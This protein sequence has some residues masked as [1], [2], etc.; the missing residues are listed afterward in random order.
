[1]TLSEAEARAHHRLDKKRMKQPPPPK[2][3]KMRRSKVEMVKNELN[4][5]Y[6]I[7]ESGSLIFATD[8]EVSLWLEL[9]ETKKKL[10]AVCQTQPL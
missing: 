6:I 7:Q 1:M 9:Q 4:E 3:W 10:E 2:P 5:W 8:F